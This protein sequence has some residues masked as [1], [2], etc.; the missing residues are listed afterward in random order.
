MIVLYSAICIVFFIEFL[1]VYCH[2]IL[3]LLIFN[4]M[5]VFSNIVRTCGRQFYIL[6]M[7]FPCL[8]KD[9]LLL[10]YYYCPAKLVGD[11]YTLIIITF[12]IKIHVNKMTCMIQYP[13]SKWA[14]TPPVPPPSIARHGWNLK[15]TVTVLLHI[16]KLL[17]I[18]CDVGWG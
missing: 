16:L 3:P 14:S 1:Y 17:F 5:V 8:N 10:L 6:N 15:Y 7:F 2:F 13:S 9:I 18:I 12:I 4:D 11:T